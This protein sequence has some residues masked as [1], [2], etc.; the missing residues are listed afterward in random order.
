MVWRSSLFLIPR[1]FEAPPVGVCVCVCPLS[2]SEAV[3]A[4][5][6][7]RRTRKRKQRLQVKEL[8][9]LG[10]VKCTSWAGLGRGSLSTWLA[11]GAGGPGTCTASLPSCQ[12]SPDLKE[13]HSDT[14]I[15]TSERETPAHTSLLSV[16]PAVTRDLIASA[17]SQQQQRFRDTR[18]LWASP[19]PGAAE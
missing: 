3:E 1:A 8:R 16:C 18:S 6:P 2:S 10:R 7:G 9:E 11:V 14:S 19:P 5:L 13:A 15:A 17:P 12:V 4:A